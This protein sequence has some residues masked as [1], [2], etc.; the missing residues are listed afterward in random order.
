MKRKFDSTKATIGIYGIKDF[1][2]NGHPGYTHDHN[3]T[4]M[5]Q[6]EIITH[7]QLERL[8][9]KKHDNRIDEHL[10][11]IIKKLSEFIDI[12]NCDWVFADSFAGRSFISSTG[13]I[14]FEA[15]LFP[16]SLKYDLEN[17]NIWVKSHENYIKKSGF[18][19]S[20]EIAHIA[21]CIPFFGDFKE[22]SLIIHF[23]GGASLSNFSAWGKKNGRIR[24]IEFHWD[25]YRNAALF[26][27]NP[28]AFNMVNCT[29]AEL[30]SVAGKLMG[31][32]SVHSFNIDIHQWL[33]SND[34]F[35][36]DD[37]ASSK[38][39]KEANHKFGWNSLKF[40]TR[41]PFL[42]TIAS[43]F[44]H[45]FEIAVLQ[46]IT[47]LQ[48]KDRWVNL[49][50]AGGCALNIILNTKLINENIFKEIFIPPCCNDTGLSLGAAA[51][52]ESFKGHKVKKHNSYLN[53]FGLEK[54]Q[55]DL[56]NKM[57]EEVASL[58]N[59]GE[60]I[61]VFNGFAEIGPRALGNR[62]LIGRPDILELKEKLS[63]SMKG[64]EWYRPVAPIMLES[65]VL[66]VTGLNS[67]PELSK[68]MLMD[69]QI[70]SEYSDKLK[71]VIHYNGTSRI[72]TLFENQ[73]NPFMFK[74]LTEIQN[75]YGI[76]AL[77]N[78]SFNKQGEPIVHTSENAIDSAKIMGLNYIVINGL[79][80][81][82]SSAI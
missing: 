26:H 49:Y 1:F 48:S 8:T 12:D 65:N 78:T 4:I 74:L 68:Y 39:M 77:M 45:E 76:I 64:R 17:S 50:M 6:G 9:R 38:F 10:D 57:I 32:S 43:S 63:E 2:N 36:N 11:D 51:L 82:I 20:H 13:K 35:I 53:N 56:S 34:F 29:Q 14:R 7:L 33:V 54:Q 30:S 58:I 70:K 27:G 21:S 22:N 19:V 67:I 47:N 52:L 42:Q 3:I 16:V 79:L 80:H 15:P 5:N 25:L 72:Q 71:G 28:L 59:R 31:F 46:K 23:D 41:D 55:I 73:D 62:S 40:D 69:F 75:K 81:N 37:Y 44:Q 18:S 60:I 24:L 66:K 61:G